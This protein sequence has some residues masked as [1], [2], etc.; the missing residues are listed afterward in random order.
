MFRHFHPK[1][2]LRALLDYSNN[3]YVNWRVK[4]GSCYE[5]AS[6]ENPTKIKGPQNVFMEED[7]CISRSLIMTPYR[8]QLY[9]ENERYTR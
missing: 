6:V 5:T 2:M 1:Q 8:K 7:T 4:L 3:Y 9:V